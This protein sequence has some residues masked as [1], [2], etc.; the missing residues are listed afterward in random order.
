MHARDIVSRRS[1]AQDPSGACVVIDADEERL[2]VRSSDGVVFRVRRS[3]LP[4]WSPSAGDSVLV[5]RVEGEAWVVG[6]L[7]AAAPPTL[8]GPDGSL[9]RV[10]DGRIELL[11][12]EGRRVAATGSQ[13]TVIE[14]AAGDLVLRAPGGRVRVEAAV[15]VELT[16]ARDVVAR[17]GRDVV[18]RAARRAELAACDEDG[19]GTK[20][21]LGRRSLEAT[22]ER[23]ALHA[24]EAELAAGELSILSRSVTTRALALTEVVGRVER[25]A[26]SVTLRAKERLEDVTGHAHTR[27]GRATTVVQETYALRSRRTELV[28]EDDTAIDGRK[29]LLG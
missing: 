29:V 2:A 19:K 6:V 17:A 24:K 9:A 4:G 11:D 26:D 20:L 15:D 18:D 22:T 25:T 8:Q 28:S 12:R 13:G 3:F 14:A 10:V 7:S 16:A 23:F 27:L 5:S 1:R 21:E